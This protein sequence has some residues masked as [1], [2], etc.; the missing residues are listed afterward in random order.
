M[1][2]NIG[3]YI[4][5]AKIWDW[6]GY[7]RTKE[8]EFWLKLA[9]KYGKNV[10]SP[11]A[12]IGEASAYLAQNGFKVT[13]SDITKE[14]V[15]EGLKRYGDIP[16]LK[17]IQSDVCDFNLSEKSYDFAFVGTTDLHH[18]QT[19]DDIRKALNCIYQHL[20]SEGGLGLELWYPSKESWKS[21]KRV[22]HSLKSKDDNK[23]KIW[24]E[25]ETEYNSENQKVSISQT[26]YIQNEDKTESF[27]HEFELQLYSRNTLLQTLSECG[28][29]IKA[30]YGG[31]S[32]ETW[33][34]NSSNWILEVI[35]K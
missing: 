22:F 31:Y 9:E 32:F 24:K 11:M 30:E 12:A 23:I 13:A 10:L 17:F 19:I 6:S 8:F 34:P 15:E 3:N 29:C 14:M 20:R 2:K 33:S 25:A 1:S 18:L 28:Y 4:K 27:I 7:D 16:D 26:V 35:K 5:H 21:P